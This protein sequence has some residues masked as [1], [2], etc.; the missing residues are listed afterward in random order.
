MITKRFIDYKDARSY[1]QEQ[2]FDYFKGKYINIG[3]GYEHIFIEEFKHKTN[4]SLCR[5]ADLRFETYKRKNENDLPQI[6]GFIQVSIK[7]N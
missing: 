1:V 2:G 6:I 4:E 5:V 7:N 3:E